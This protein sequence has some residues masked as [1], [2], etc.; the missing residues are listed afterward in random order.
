MKHHKYN[1]NFKFVLNPVEFNKHTDK[2]LLQYCLGATLY[3]PATKDFTRVILDN[4]LPGLTSIVL[5]FEDAIPLDDLYKAE[6][7]AM[8]LLEV[9]TKEVEY[10][11]LEMEKIPLVFFRIRSLEQFVNISN[12]LKPEYAK[13]LTGFVF[14]KFSISNGILYLDHL[15]Y[16]NEKYGELLYGMPILESEEIAIKE[17]RLNEL[18]GIKSLLEPYKEI[19]LN[20]RVGATDLSSIFGVRRGMNY[21][22]YDILPVN[23]CLS[24]ILNIFIRYNDF[25]VSAPV[26]EYFAANKD[27]GLEKSFNGNIQHTLLKRTPVVDD[28]I[29]GLLRE[30]IMD[31]ANGFV[32]KTIIHPSHIK[33]VNAMQAVVKEE[34]ED[35]MQILKVPGGVVKSSYLNKMNEINPHKC[36]AV[37]ICLRAQAYGVIESEAE[38]L[39]L[40]L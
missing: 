20:V 25:V 7:N 17:T 15:R 4:M 24:D 19:I 21:S 36:W 2:Q 34:Y 38:F 8:L 13:L 31:K 1:P 37:K 16:L 30:V 9:L 35:A 29:D 5:C 40:F 3:M 33:Y 18:L 32:G 39:K 28:V 26:W 23:D 12:Q 14:P 27:I 6:E 10:G 22:I 11:N